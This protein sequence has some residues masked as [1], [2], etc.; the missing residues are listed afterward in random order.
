MDDF[1]LESTRRS[2]VMARPDGPLAWTARQALELVDE[3]VAAR[4]RIAE[5]ERNDG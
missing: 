4:Q 2:L 1:E 3:L 5:L